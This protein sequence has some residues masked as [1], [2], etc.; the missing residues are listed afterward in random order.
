M[1]TLGIL[2]SQN[3]IDGNQGFQIITEGNFTSTGGH[4]IH[5]PLAVGGNLII[6]N[7]ATGEINMDNT[8][9]YIFPGD[10]STSTGLMVAGSVTWTAGNLKAVSY[11]HLRLY[12]HLYWCQFLFGPHFGGS[13]GHRLSGCSFCGK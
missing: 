11:T 7:S 5:G 4:H 1:L 8:G 6:N 9:S 10:G 13:L 12:F 3:P 2:S